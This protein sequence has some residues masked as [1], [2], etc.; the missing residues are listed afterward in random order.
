MR[1]RPT[2]DAAT[3]AT[4]RPIRNGS[5]HRLCVA[6][7][8]DWTDRHC[9]FFHRLLTAH[10]FLY[11]EMVTAEAILHGRRERLLAFSPEEHPVVLQLGGSDPRRLAQAAAIGESF[12][13]DEI[14]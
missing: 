3:I 6:P 1:A 7:M 13:Y 14:N 2:A 5:I 10:A 11:T 12:G 8:M 4:T 9:R